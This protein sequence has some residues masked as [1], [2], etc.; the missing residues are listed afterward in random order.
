LYTYVGNNPVNYVDPTG[1][2]ACTPEDAK[3]GECSATADAKVDTSA[4]I[5]SSA[6]ANAKAVVTKTLISGTEYLYL[7]SDGT[8]D[9]IDD[10]TGTSSYL[11]EYGRYTMTGM[12]EELS[13]IT[14]W[15]TALEIDLWVT[16]T[17]GL[18]QGGGKHAA[19]LSKTEIGVATFVTYVIGRVVDKYAPVPS[20]GTTTIAVY[21]Q[22]ADGHYERLAFTIAPDGKSVQILAG[23]WGSLSGW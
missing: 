22:T 13:N 9:V 14:K 17:T 11:T 5:D 15:A 19:P 4:T 6:A 20:A 23:G 8:Y 10:T 21:R 16:G 18:G 1:H 7:Y 3:A 12:N 2:A